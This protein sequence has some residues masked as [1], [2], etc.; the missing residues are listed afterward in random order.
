MQADLAVF[1]KKV[2]PD[3]GV[4]DLRALVESYKKFTR[5][6]LIFDTEF[7]RDAVPF[8]QVLYKN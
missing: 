2:R 4:P 7:F 3:P 6:S 8:F 1:V 5:F